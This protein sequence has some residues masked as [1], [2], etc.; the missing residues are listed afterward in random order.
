M[1]IKYFLKAGNLKTMVAPFKKIFTA[2]RERIR[3][4]RKQKSGE[5]LK[6]NCFSPTKKSTA[7]L[8]ADN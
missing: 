5:L 6:R 1:E 4:E 8:L 7:W 2:L 3:L